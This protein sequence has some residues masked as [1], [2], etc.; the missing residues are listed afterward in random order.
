MPRRLSIGLA[1]TDIGF[2]L[3]WAISLLDVMGVIALP[4]SWMYEGYGDPHICAW[5]WSFLPVD[6]LFSVSGLASVAAARRG[7]PIWRPLALLSLS[8]TMIAGLMAISY[9]GLMG[10]FEPAWFLPNLA[11]VVWPCLFLP[12]LV[13]D[14]RARTLG[15]PSGT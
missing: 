13:S 12:S 6:L 1:V 9:W 8:F 14:I 7:D 2:L 5:N 11:I 10:T 3:Y 4:R 15:A